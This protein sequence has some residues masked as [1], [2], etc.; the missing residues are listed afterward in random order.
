[1]YAFAG[2]MR[3]SWPSIVQELT[4]L[5]GLFSVTV[6]S[7]FG[8]VSETAACRYNTDTD[9]PD[10]ISPANL[11]QFKSSGSPSHNQ[12]PSAAWDP[13]LQFLSYLWSS[14][15]V[16][17]RNVHTSWSLRTSRRSPVYTSAVRKPVLFLDSE[18][19]FWFV[20]NICQF[21]SQSRCRR[22]RLQR[23]KPR[24]TFRASSDGASLRKRGRSQ[25]SPSRAAG[26]PARNA[27]SRVLFCGD[28]RHGELFELIVQSWPVAW[29]TFDTT[30]RCWK[31]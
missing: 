21:H 14:D 31:T 1:M 19:Y 2:T 24:V 29:Q 25:P 3:G 28:K 11:L 22:R 16:T 15:G 23:S 7:Q 10:T 5:V 13:W 6:T 30:E 17:Q 12:K 26:R 18:F 20:G 8:E 27:G 9:T 4:T